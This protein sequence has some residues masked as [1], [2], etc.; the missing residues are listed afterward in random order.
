MATLSDSLVSSAARKLRIRK[1]PDL[2]ARRQHYLGESY[3]VVKD[4]VGLNYYRFQEEE[5]AILNMLDGDT[6]LDEIKER[7]EAQ[8]PP[9]KITL[10]ELQQFLGTLH[11]SGLVIAS[12]PE[13]GQ[14]LHKRSGDRKRKELV[15]TFSNILAIRF[16]GIDPERILTALYPWTRWLFH[17]VTLW[18]CVLAWAGALL[19]IMVHFQVFRSKL[20]EFYQFFTPT[21]ALWMAG[22]LAVTKIFHEFGHGLACKHFRGECHEMGVMILV[23]TPCLY[24]NVSDS[25]ML[26]NKW[27]RAGIG[28]AGIFSNSRSLRWPRSS[29]GS[30]NPA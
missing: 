26:P 2:S 6:S 30:A 11:R 18:L 23:L 24:C 1:R 7:F 28:A 20:P 13:Q 25:W 9:Q 16:K 19:L 22:V 3:W 14:Q 17:P 5:F 29:G 21:N 8:F 10:E 27:Y 4:P 12:V 15:N